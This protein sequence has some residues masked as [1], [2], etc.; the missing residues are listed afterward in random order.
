MVMFPVGHFFFILGFKNSLQGE[1]NFGRQFFSI[2]SVVLEAFQMDEHVLGH[3]PQIE[4]F[5]S[6]LFLLTHRAS[7]KVSS[8]EA[9]RADI[10][11]KAV[12]ELDCVCCIALRA[13][14]P[15]VVCRLDKRTDFKGT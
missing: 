12:A 3:L 11:L 9:F 5:H 8:G 15:I 10:Q 13:H 2:K 6:W 4:F 14:N 7:P 1:S